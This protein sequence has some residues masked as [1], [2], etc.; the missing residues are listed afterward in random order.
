[1]ISREGLQGSFSSGI[2]R[3]LWRFIGGDGQRFTFRS[4]RGS[5][6]CGRHC[7]EL[8]VTVEARSWHARVTLFGVLNAVTRPEVREALVALSVVVWDTLVSA[9]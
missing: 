4:G 5:S 8:Y 3:V 7:E 1:M 6:P 9:L 2:E